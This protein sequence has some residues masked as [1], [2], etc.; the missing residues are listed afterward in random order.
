M[1]AGLGDKLFYDLTFT[2]NF[3]SQVQVLPDPGDGITNS[4]LSFSSGY[5]SVECYASCTPYEM[6]GRLG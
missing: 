5:F 3:G 4:G 6:C 2:G 1:R